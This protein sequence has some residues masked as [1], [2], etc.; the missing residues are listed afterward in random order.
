MEELIKVHG[1]YGIV[2]ILLKTEQSR[3]KGIDDLQIDI[4]AENLLEAIGC[5]KRQ[6][7]I[8]IKQINE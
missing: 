1:H 3:I 6:C 8:A 2:S 4:K 7:K 5:I